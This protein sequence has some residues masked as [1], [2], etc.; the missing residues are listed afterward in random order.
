MDNTDNPLA[1]EPASKQHSWK[2]VLFGSYSYR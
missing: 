2:N 1:I